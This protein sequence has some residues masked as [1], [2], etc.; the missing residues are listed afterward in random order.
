[1]LKNVRVCL[2]SCIVQKKKKQ[3]TTNLNYFKETASSDY[4][5]TD[6][7]CSLGQ[8]GMGAS[9]ELKILACACPIIFFNFSNDAVSGHI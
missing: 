3:L 6:F 5:L 7:E 4:V 1:M 9:R 2:R 8:E